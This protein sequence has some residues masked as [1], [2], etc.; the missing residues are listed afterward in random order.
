MP[1][2][3]KEKIAEETQNVLAAL[4]Q[5]AKE[6]L[7]KIAQQCHMS[8]QKLQRIIRHLEK[9]RK[10][11]GYTAIVDEQGDPY[12]KFILLLKRTMEKFDDTKMDDMISKRFKPLYEQFGFALR[13]RIISMA[14]TIGWW[15]LL[16]RTCCRR[17]NS[18]KSYLIIIL[19]TLRR[20]TSWRYC[21]RAGRTML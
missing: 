8:K 3:S 17:K 2:Q 19:G 1:K 20:W 21:L 10:I 18:V 13:V 4:Q 7:T 6:N 11:W 12:K 14:S 5:N 9:T 16:P 15:F